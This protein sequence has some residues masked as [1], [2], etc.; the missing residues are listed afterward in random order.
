MLTNIQIDNF[1][2]IDHLEVEFSS[3]MTVLTGETGAGKSIIIDALSL[4]LGV[5]ADANVIRSGSN[6]ADISASFD[7]A[8]LS[9]VTAW[10]EEHELDDEGECLLRRIINKEG[11]SKGFI[12]GHPATLSM[13]KALGEQLVDIHGQHAH[14]ALLRPG[15][16]C[17]L[18]D[19]YAQ[20][21][22][23]KDAVKVSWEQW[24][25]L[26]DEHL[27]L[28]HSEQE[29]HDRHELLDYQVRELDEF[30]IDDKEISNI[31]EEFN[32]LA[33]MNQ[34][35][36]VSEQ[37]QQ[38]LFHD[39]N[40]SA[41]E[42]VNSAAV[43]INELASL[44]PTLSNISDILE[45]ASI[46]IQEA[47]IEL[48]TYQEQLDQDPQKLA[49]L[50]QRLSQLHALGRKH[51]VDVQALP[52]LHQRLH[53]ELNRLNDSSNR[54]HL[55]EQEV[56]E[57]KSEYLNLAQKLSQSR[58]QAAT[59]LNKKISDYLSQLGMEDG[60]FQVEF[61]LL[62]ESHYHAQGI[63][64]VQFLVTANAG[65]PLQSINKVASG[66][67]LSR[68]SLAI[69]VVTATG[70][71]IPC[72][73]FDEVDVG[74]GGGTAEVVGNL[75]ATIAK[76]AQVLC[77]THQAQVASKG[78]QHYQIKKQ[79]D[80]NITKT[81]VESLESEQRKEEIARMIGGI[82]ITEQTRKYAEEMLTR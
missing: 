75:L 37:Q 66:G 40:G 51:R 4:V 30:G 76:S 56:L 74:I 63:E 26:R 17:K 79:S 42:I 3:G 48:R 73:I 49:Q 77:V 20:L 23:I 60:Q 12:N 41:F 78:D 70:T 54:S 1:A 15:M 45:S 50:D 58:H 80:G 33:N 6:R 10:L 35:L 61:T 67:E 57:A 8:S 65:Q 36:E 2:I 28:Q 59:T 55:L 47:S 38:R 81:K 22:S 43:K 71:S 53:D 69:Q 9:S 24:K 34:L 7:I 14:Q 64:K 27:Q 5:R 32:R 18:L 52:K 62:E 29:R 82:T 46:Q 19:D 31:D 68:I 16:Q 72:L 39:E 21:S 13:L 11:R 25:S 44:D